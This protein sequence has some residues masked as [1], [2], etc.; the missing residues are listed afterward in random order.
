MPQSLLPSPI[1]TIR[2]R[3]EGAVLTAV[4]I[5]PGG[6]DD[7]I[8][9]DALTREG[10]A[11][12][13]AWFAGRLTT[14]DLPLAAAA[15][16]RGPA[17]RAAIVAVGFGETASYGAVARAIGSSPRAVGQA[18]RRNPFPIIVPC[19]RILAAGGGIGHYSAGA[20][21]AAKRWL[22][23]HERRKDAG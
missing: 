14:F 8:A 17:H 21:V 5:V 10:A 11:Q 20:G 19:H 1:G 3:A 13:A 12:L 6:A 9:E 4:E 15:S 7:D 16:A 22:L 2:I 18:C 23:D